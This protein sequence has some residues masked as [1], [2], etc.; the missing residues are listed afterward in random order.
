MPEWEI[1]LYYIPRKK[2]L[3]SQ[4]EIYLLLKQSSE[5]AKSED[6]LV[7]FQINSEVD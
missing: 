1:N 3:N 7:K 2:E 4:W 5:N 6:I